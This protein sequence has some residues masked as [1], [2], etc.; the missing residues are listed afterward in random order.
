M[1]VSV[2]LGTS[3]N[4]KLA[5]V[6]VRSVPPSSVK[7]WVP[8]SGVTSET[9]S[10]GGGSAAVAGEVTASV[11]RARTEDRAAG[12]RRVSTSGLNRTQVNRRAIAGECAAYRRW[13]IVAR[14]CDQTKNG[15]AHV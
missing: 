13:Q 15:R 4:S 10:A 14:A 1:S 8:L 11:A 7:V 5:W 9:K 6:P 3:K 12:I 2:G